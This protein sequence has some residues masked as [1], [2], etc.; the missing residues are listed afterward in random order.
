VERCVCRGRESALCW[1]EGSR[2]ARPRRMSTDVRVRMGAG[3]LEELVSICV[4]VL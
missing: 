2:H 1:A 4:A 3:V